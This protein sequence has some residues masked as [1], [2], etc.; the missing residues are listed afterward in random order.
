MA[1]PQSPTVAQVISD[2]RNDLNSV[3]LDGHLPSRYL[4]NKLIDTAKLFMKR[5]AD[6]RRIQQYQSIWVTVDSFEMEET[7]L[8]G[9]SDIPIPSCTKVM[10]SKLQL[11]AIY[12]TRYGYLLNIS[13]VD[14]NR[15]YMQFTPRAYAQAKTRRYHNPDKRYF[16]IYNGYLI[17]PD[18]LV[19]SVTLRAVFCYKDQ[20]LKLDSCNDPSC[21]RLLDQEFTAPGHLLD[22]I[23]SKTVQ[24]I[25]GIRDKIPSDEYPNLN[26]LEKNSPLS[27]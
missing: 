13:S 16:W 4:H 18:S 23:K 21:I 26:S 14:Y 2:V 9:C 17:I 8:V 7:P 15:E 25:A 11:P 22:D 1:T 12:S 20:G 3:S 24:V 27:K 19:Q 6:D 5:E 10:K